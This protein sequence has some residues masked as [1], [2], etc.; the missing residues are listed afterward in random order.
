MSEQ[1]TLPGPENTPPS[2]PLEA[3]DSTAAAATATESSGKTTITTAASVGEAS[4][5]TPRG[6]FP[7]HGLLP[8]TDTQAGEFVRKNPSYDGR[9]TVVAVL[10]TGIDPGAQGLQTT[11]DGKRKVV[12][13]VDCTGSGDVELGEPQRCASGALELRGASGR[14]L[15][16]NAEWTNPTGEWRVGAKRLYDIAPSSVRGA[17]KRERE[18]RFR[19]EAQRVA[20]G[21]GAQRGKESKQ[22]K[23]VKE[24]KEDKEKGKDGDKESKMTE[25]DA[26]AAALALLGTAY[27]DSGAMLDCVVFHDG[28]QWRAAVDTEAAG[29]LTHAHAMGAYKTTGDVALLSR[30][31]LLYFTLNFYDDGR[32]LSIVVSAGPH[33]THVSGILAA[34]HADEPQNNGVAPGAQLVSLLIGDHRVAS[35]ETG[36]ALTRAAAAIVEHGADLANMSFGEPSA[37]HNAGQWVQTLRAEVVRRHRCVFVA[38]AGNEGPALTTVGAPG[39]TTAGVIGVGAFVGDEQMRT[40]H[41][42]YEFVHD[43]SFTW[44]SRGPTADGARGCDVFAPGSA[45]ASYPAYT[46]QR[47]RLANGTSMSSPNLC[48]CLA[49]LVSAWK[50]QQQQQQQNGGASARISPYRISNALLATARPFGDELGAGLVQTDDAWQFL[51]RHRQRV[52]ED[53]DYA[54]AVLDMGGARGVYLRNAEDSAQPRHLKVS[55]APIFV[56]DAGDALEFDADGRR[57]QAANQRRF[58][59]EQR[60]LLTADAPWVRVPDALYLGSDGSVFS[61][62]VDATRLEPGR[63]HVATIRGFDSGAVERGPIFTVPVTVTKP[64]AVG[65]GAYVRLGTLSFQP[66][67]VVRRFIAVPAGATRARIVLRTPNAEAHAAAPALFYLHCLQLAPQERF[68]AYELKERV[69]IGHPSFAAGAGSAE[70][71]YQRFMDVLGG[72][73]LEVCVAQFWNQ[74]DG[75]AVDV[76]VD[77]HGITPAGSQSARSPGGASGLGAAIAINGNYGVVRADFSAAVRPEYGVRPKATLDVLRTALRPLS[78]TVAP[79]ASERDIHPASGVAIHRLVLDYALETKSDGATIR[80]RLPALD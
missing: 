10:D 20:D 40:D 1:T 52:Y 36:V 42:M 21:V 4:S 35:L 45:I 25:L 54:V 47:L 11:S 56:D 29:D 17:A 78:A 59:F 13:F 31:Q 70:Q 8:R 43:T 30:R 62:M 32:I 34:N 38:S 51:M 55:V 71:R 46:Q 75:H 49:L 44:S 80:P 39:G 79:C 16:L 74:V 26:Q 24:D 57:G 72:A 68:T 66:T 5:S 41:G 48:G 53:V 7:T 27:E 22:G 9:G 65:P 33:A 73:T 12:D 58:D 18:E 64:L 15:R 67:D 28:T 2:T 69:S 76:A 6:P 50:Q 77:F 19:K 14:M 37:T 60:V 61:A 63:L 23:D 3:A